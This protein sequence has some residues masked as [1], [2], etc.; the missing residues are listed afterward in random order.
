MTVASARVETR[1]QLVKR[2]L[3]LMRAYLP[4]VA[5]ALR[6]DGSAQGALARTDPAALL[7]FAQRHY[8]EPVLSFL[9]DTSSLRGELPREVIAALDAARA[10]ETAIRTRLLDGIERLESAFAAAGVDWMLLKGF[11]LAVRYYGAMDRR[12][13][14]DLDV[15]VRVEHIRRAERVLKSLGYRP[16][17]WAPLR[18]LGRYATHAVDYVTV[19]TVVDLHWTLA[20][21]PSFRFDLA[22]LF[23]RRQRVQL[24]STLV[25]IPADE[26]ALVLA[27]VSAFGDL[28]R[29][30]LSARTLL[31]LQQVLAANGNVTDWDDFL[32]RRKCEGT[33]AIAVNMLALLLD[34]IDGREAFAAVASAIERAKA[35]L[36]IQPDGYADLFLPSRYA[37]ANKIWAMPLYDAPVA[38]SLIWW[39]A[40]LPVRVLVHRG[41]RS[42]V[43]R[44]ATNSGDG[45]RQAETSHR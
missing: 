19:G 1:S 16:S 5:A 24:R 3:V 35:V 40:S 21:H 8:V 43:R 37:L 18:G 42:T 6:G 39:G 28:Q 44:S 11:G 13:S 29:R 31:D 32:A 38:W 2:R 34:A 4:T 14:R 45:R 20:R 30:A 9:A 12:V 25:S 33:H 26:D 17:S 27:L 7:E 15:L 22:G 36:R 41:M 23:A 10:R